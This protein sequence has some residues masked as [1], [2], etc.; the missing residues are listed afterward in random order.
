MMP[1]LHPAPWVLVA[2]LLSAPC[3]A[4]RLDDFE[5]GLN[6]P[7]ST[8]PE[9]GHSVP[10]TSDHILGEAFEEIVLKPFVETVGDFFHVV[11]APAAQASM[12]L[13]ER[14][15]PGDATLPVLRADMF[16]Q[17]LGADLYAVD[18]RSELGYGQFLIM[19]Q[20]SD[21]QEH[22][23]KDQFIAT[24]WGLGGRFTYSENFQ[25]DVLIGAMQFSGN[26]VTT[27]ILIATPFALTFGRYAIEYRPAFADGVSEHDIAARYQ[28]RYWSGELGYRALS[29]ATA[30]LNGPYVGIGIHW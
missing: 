24:R 6:K 1:K 22:H 7:T 16:A 26:N 8:Q 15:E 30:T 2:I 13:Q 18:V 20:L 23:P 25:A 21:Y 5:S 28:R 29:N 12:L 11:F 19:A 4:G 3:Y 17:H 10:S 27:R 14:H 9:A